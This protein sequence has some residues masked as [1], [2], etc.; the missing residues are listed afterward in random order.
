MYSTRNFT[1]IL[2]V[3]ACST[4][5]A[6][7][8]IMTFR[9]GENGYA[10]AF[11][12]L[13]SRANTK[14]EHN[15][16]GADD[17][18]VHGQSDEFYPLEAGI[19]RFDDLFGNE[20]NQIPSGQTI[21]SVLLRLYLRTD[22]IG[23]GTAKGISLNPMLIGVPDFGASDGPASIGEVTWK[24]LAHGQTD[25]GPPIDDGPIKDTDYD[26][27]VV[28]GSGA[29][30]TSD[31]DSFVEVDITYIVDQWYTGQMANY[32]V[33]IRPSNDQTASYFRSND[34]STV[35][36]RPEL[37]IL[38]STIECGDGLHPYPIGDFNEDCVVDVSDLS[39]FSIHWLDCTDGN[40]PCNYGQ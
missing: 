35:A 12:T 36:E 30:Y 40:P 37:V 19:I 39:I 8:K 13:V 33:I 38:Y 10:G 6:Q 28:A 15:F 20:P 29:Y 3:L 23:G 7:P 18:S 14:E 22:L 17:I 4:V 2:F 9:Q 5:V 26:S 27:T 21:S 31:V 16:G 1:L 25:W 11:D 34:W 32:G 24:D